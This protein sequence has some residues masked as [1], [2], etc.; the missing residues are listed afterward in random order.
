[1]MTNTSH[2]HTIDL[3][4]MVT[5]TKGW[6]RTTSVPGI[7]EY[8]KLSYCYCIKNGESGISYIPKTTFVL[9]QHMN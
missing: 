6:S 7:R 8:P 4:N 2:I 1:M 3:E 5:E 9:L